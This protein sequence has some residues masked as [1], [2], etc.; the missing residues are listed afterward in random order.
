MKEVSLEDIRELER[1]VTE[2]RTVNE[3]E[4]VDAAD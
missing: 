2:K 1:A 4:D 3:K